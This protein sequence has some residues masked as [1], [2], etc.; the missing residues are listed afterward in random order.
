ML[1]LPFESEG[2]R[3]LN[4]EIFETIY[5]AAMKA[6]QMLAKK[7]GAYSSFAGSPASQGLLQYDLWGATP[8]DRWDWAG[9]KRDIALTGLRNSL[10]VAPMPTASTAQIMGNNECFE[11]YTSNIYNRRVMAGD[12]P[13]VNPHLIPD[14]I[15]LGLWTN[16]MKH[17]IIANDGSVQNIKEIPADIRELYKTAWEIKQRCLIDMA[18]DRGVFIDQVTSPP[19]KSLSWV[20]SHPG[21]LS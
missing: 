16:E 11:P 3:K 21:A 15:A 13:V 18:A 19:V 17:R 4:R 7:D 1:R 14:L 20:F 6:S 2:A 8:S 5:F 10:T 12:F 9:L